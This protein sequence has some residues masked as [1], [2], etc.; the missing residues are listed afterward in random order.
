MLLT[1]RDLWWLHALITN[2]RLDLG[3]ETEGVR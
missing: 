1:F 3:P 2:A